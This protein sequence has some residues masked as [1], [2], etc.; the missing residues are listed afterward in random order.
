M[1]KKIFCIFLLALAFFCAALLPLPAAATELRVALV[2]GQASA[3]IG[4]E[5]EFAVQ[6]GTEKNLLPAGRYFLTVQEDKLVLE[7]APPKSKRYEFASALEIAP[8]EKKALPK[9]NQRAYRGYLR[10]LAP[11]GK[12]LLVNHIDCED[13]LASV[14][15]RKTMV[16]W[17]DEVI[18]AQAVAA[19]SYA[20][21]RKNSRSA[22][23]YDLLANDA[24]LNYAGS[25]A[26]I[27]KPGITKIVRAT[28]G[29]YLA[30]ASGAI[31]LCVS[32]SSSGGRTES[33]LD[34]WGR[35]VSYLQS[36]ADDDSDSPDY[37]WEH[38]A[39]PALL[40]GQLAQ[41]G[42]VVGKINSVRLSPLN[43]PD[44]D[45]TATGRV[46]YLIFSGTAGT[47][48]I[49]AGELAEMLELPS[50]FFDVETGTPPPESLKVPIEDRFGFE[51]GSKDIDIKVKEDERPVWRK[52]LR[53][54]HLLS[55]SKT[56]KIIFH[57]RGRGSGMGLSAWGARGMAVADEKTT[58]RKILAYYYPGTSLIEP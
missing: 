50:T 35:E 8:L 28:R 40:E 38:R 47:V 3:E 46:R 20:L 42:Y 5:S 14:L 16:V 11:D 44:D 7:S 43:F 27:E 56:E 24:E 33:A 34:A 48:K 53:S 19:R 13:Y 18:K 6:S 17:P 36:L 37:R 12:I 49:D 32:T 30:D 54:F 10:A 39:T 51:V 55:G 21:A 57:G 15:P 31:A 41:R 25:G 58:Y 2:I 45:R 4:C 29:E 26:N 1:R 52:L 9:V 23:R 22:E